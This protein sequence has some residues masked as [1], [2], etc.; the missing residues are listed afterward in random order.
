MISSSAL[1]PSNLPLVVLIFLLLSTV[2]GFRMGSNIALKSHVYNGAR[3]ATVLNAHAKK[4]ALSSLSQ[5]FFSV[6]GFPSSR[7]LLRELG[8]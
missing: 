5:C 1:L 7:L 4:V 3:S 2:D 6:H 8:W